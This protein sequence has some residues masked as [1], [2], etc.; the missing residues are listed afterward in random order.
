MEIDTISL[1][2]YFADSKLCDHIPEDPVNTDFTEEDVIEKIQQNFYDYYIVCYSGGKDSTD[3]LLKLLD[4]GVPRSKIELHHHLIDGCEGSNLMDVIVTKDYCQKFA[5]AFKI[6]IYF[7]WKVHGFE[8]EMTKVN[9]RSYPVKWQTPDGIIKQ[10]GGI[11]SK[12]TTRMMFPQV[13]ANLMR[14]WCSAYLKIDVLSYLINNSPRF[15]GKN[16]LVITGERAEESSSRA[17]Y[18]TFKPHR[19]DLRNGKRYQRY[20]DHWMPV[21]KLKTGEIWESIKKHNVIPHPQYYA[22]FG[23]LS[24]H[25]C[26]FGNAN[27]FRSAQKISPKRFQRLVDYEHEFEVFHGRKQTM[28]QKIDLESLVKKGTAYKGITPELIEIL[29]S[30]EYNRPI[31]CKEGEWIEPSGAFADLS[32]GSQ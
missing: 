21:H 15:I 29:E 16:T 6:P 1:D 24:C 26:I 27:Q 32:G 23:R 31:F 18:T 19:T 12:I 9:R 17:K 20:V 11:Q 5:D 25:F 7:S 8:G 14:R 2:Y 3:S 30:E 22:G 13:E 10:A 28:K 4:L